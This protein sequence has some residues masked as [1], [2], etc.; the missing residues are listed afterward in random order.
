M[1]YTYTNRLTDATVERLL[2]TT[3]SLSASSPDPSTQNGALIYWPSS[4]EIVGIGV[5]TFPTGIEVTDERLERPLK[6]EY[7]EHAERNAIYMAAYK[8][9]SVLKGSVMVC[10]WAACSDCARALIQ[11]GITTLVRHKDALDRSP[12]RWKETI[13]IADSMMQEAGVE[14]VDYDGYL[15]A[16]TILHSGELF[17]P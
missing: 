8:G 15:N 4:N 3:Y 14:I 17:Y 10:Q 11:T 1:T 12:D 9:V 6:Y 5:N 16:S 13:A 7:I 2:R